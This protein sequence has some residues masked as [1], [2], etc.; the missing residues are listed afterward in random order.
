M[1][2]VEKEG[3]VSFLPTRATYDRNLDFSRFDID[4]EETPSDPRTLSSYLF[5]DRGVYRP[6]DRFNIGLITRTANWA[7]ALD[8]VPCGR[9]SVTHEIP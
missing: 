9:R 7:T 2:L 6:G 8:G 4:G 1:F 5:S 3:D